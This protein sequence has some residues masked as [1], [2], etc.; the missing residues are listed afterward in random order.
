LALEKVP[1]AVT[2]AVLGHSSASTTLEVYT[3]VAPELAREAAE[4]MD[5]VSGPS[6]LD[7]T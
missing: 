5:R 2:M 7:A 6:E 4:A 3:R 1:A